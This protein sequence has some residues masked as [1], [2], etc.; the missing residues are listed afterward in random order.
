[1]IYLCF[2]VLGSTAD[3]YL[4]PVLVSISKH[5]KLS[6]SLAGVTFLAFGNGAADV[7]SALSA[8][9]DIDSFA[10]GSGEGFYL[11]AA[12]SLGAG[13]FVSS[14]VSSFV[15]LYTATQST[16]EPFLGETGLRVRG[17]AS[18]AVTPQAF[19]RDT[20]FYCIA[21]LIMIYAIF[22]G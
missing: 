3:A 6:Q 16:G 2:Y 17:Q 13:F 18:T 8:S 14:I 7:F 10:K 11:A 22:F 21:C 12:A 9:S 19:I 15:V 20:A 5:L 4:S 1:M